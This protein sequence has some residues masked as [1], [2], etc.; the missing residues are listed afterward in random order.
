ML[1]ISVEDFFA[2]VKALPS[3]TREGERDLAARMAAGDTA[4]R[5]EL[6]RGYL[7]MVAACLR[8]APSSVQT[9]DTVYACIATLEQGVDRFRFEQTGETFAHHLSWRLRQCIT[10]CVARRP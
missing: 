7:P 8:R 5:E 3:L 2:Q 9:L 10:R 4:A 6:V 1:F